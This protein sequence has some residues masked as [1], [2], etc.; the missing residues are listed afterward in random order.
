MSIIDEENIRAIV[1]EEA[2]GA[3]MRFYHRTDKHNEQDILRTIVAQEVDKALRGDLHTSDMLHDLHVQYEVL[4]RDKKRLIELCT[5]YRHVAEDILPRP[6]AYADARMRE[7][8][9][10]LDAKLEEYTG[11]PHTSA[12]AS[13]V[14]L[15]LCHET[16]SMLY[17]L[18]NDAVKGNQWSDLH[19]GY[20]T[21][22][23]FDLTEK[24]AH[25]L[26]NL[27]ERSEPFGIV[28]NGKVEVK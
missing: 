14:T 26:M 12:D 16:A 13:Y 21:S 18:L 20:E 1:R 27:L 17:T 25:E 2:Y 7:E 4:S 28:V 6:N 22:I 10:R 8:L 24:Q 11:V 3:L 9:T 5:G 19:D 15:N 23:M